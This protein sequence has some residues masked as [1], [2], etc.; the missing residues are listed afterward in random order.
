M[1]KTPL[2]FFL[3]RADWQRLCEVPWGLPEFTSNGLLSGFLVNSQSWQE[4]WRLTQTW[5]LF[6]CKSSLDQDSKLYI[7]IQPPL[8]KG[9]MKWRGHTK[10]KTRLQDE[11]KYFLNQVHVKYLTLWVVEFLEEVSH[12][13]KITRWSD[14]IVFGS[15]KCHQILW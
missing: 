11:D 4:G 9:N 1:N 3:W 5:G 13:F 8:K 12:L 7:W 6:Q 10:E 14:P 15:I 2:D